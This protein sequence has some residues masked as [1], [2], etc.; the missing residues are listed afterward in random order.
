[1]NL[2]AVGVS[3]LGPFIGVES[4]VTITQMLWVNIIMDTL[5][6]L[7]FA[8]E[9]SR[10]EYMKEMPKPRDEKII[11][12]EMIGQ[13]LGN[14]LYILAMCVWFLK[15]DSLPM[16]LTRGDDKYIMCA[17][18][19]TFIFTGIFVCFTSRTKRLN[20]LSQ[21]SKNKSF[22]IIMLLISVTQMGFIYFGGELFRAT[23]LKFDDLITIILISFS[24]VIFDLL[25]KIA[26]KLFR[27]KRK[28]QTI[29]ERENVK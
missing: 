5:G 26:I 23:P 28:T 16:L 3:L 2:S 19:A 6:A 4:P 22:L 20:I 9:P 24:V 29:G 25:R 27:R 13:I 18:F 21:I 15:S 8:K 1:M 12:R 17:F 14:G 10:T 7:A 11:S